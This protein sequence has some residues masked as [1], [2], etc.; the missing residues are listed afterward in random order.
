MMVHRA[1]QTNIKKSLSLSLSLSLSIYI[2][3]YL[4]THTH[5]GHGCSGGLVA[6]SGV[7]ILV[8][9]A[10][11]TTFSLN[12][13]TAG[14]TYHHQLVDRIPA[15]VYFYSVIFGFIRVVVAGS[16]LIFV[17]VN[18]LGLG[19]SCLQIQAKL[20]CF[21][22]GLLELIFEKREKNKK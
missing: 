9:L 13:T 12:I 6:H 2:Y 15:Q 22:F 17:W 8:K 7:G 1:Q 19:L 14:S 4:Q 21:L 18:F 10:V 3:I 11:A 16:G 20:G 5:L